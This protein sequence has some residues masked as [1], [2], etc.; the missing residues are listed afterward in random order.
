MELHKALKEIVA[1]KG[2]GM[3]NNTQ[4]INF[5]LD[6]QAFKEKPAIKLIV[7]DEIISGYAEKVHFL[8][9]EAAFY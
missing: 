5:L 7:R 3:I 8:D 2:A 6:Y 9:T 4:I 1:Q